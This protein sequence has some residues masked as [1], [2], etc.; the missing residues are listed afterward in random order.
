MET[1]PRFE[2]TFA[3]VEATDDEALALW[4][5]Y[6]EDVY[7]FTPEERAKKIVDQSG[8]AAMHF[9]RVNT[10]IVHMSDRHHTAQAIYEHLVEV[11]TEEITNARRNC[12]EP[13]LWKEDLHSI[14][15]YV[16]YIAGRPIVITC[17]W[18]TIEGHLVLFY[19]PS[20]QL[21]DYKMIEQWLE[22]ATPNAVI[23]V[24]AQNFT[25]VITTIMRA[26]KC[27]KNPG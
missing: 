16:G 11:F 27:P 19:N 17:T 6:H 21:V 15:K 20:S 10:L 22:I 9:V 5:R 23:R 2:K 12:R 24:D 26:N 25:D 13:I 1:D 8:E 7:H 14:S 18:A 3:C 4:M